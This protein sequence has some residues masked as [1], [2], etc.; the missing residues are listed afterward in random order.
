MRGTLLT[1]GE[2]PRG[3]HF[4]HSKLLESTNVYVEHGWRCQLSLCLR[5][6]YNQC[7]SVFEVVSEFKCRVL[8]FHLAL[9]LL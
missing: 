4:A 3:Y 2:Y 9:S 6:P 8:D 5:D 7:S 1:R